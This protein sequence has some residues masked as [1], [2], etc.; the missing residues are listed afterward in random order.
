VGQY[1]HGLI[2]GDVLAACE[3]EAAGPR[4]AVHFLLEVGQD[5]R[6]LLHLIQHCPVRNLGQESP[7]VRSRELPRVQSLQ[8]DIGLLRKGSLAQGVVLPD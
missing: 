4:V 6:H 5:S 7:R 3:N 2:H 1:I 8:G